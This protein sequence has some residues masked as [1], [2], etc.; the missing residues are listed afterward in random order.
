MYN[1]RKTE[2]E[3]RQYSLELACFQIS[4]NMEHMHWLS[5]FP[6]IS[7]FFFVNN[8]GPIVCK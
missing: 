4:L 7:V 2:I 5:Y 1:A 8:P 6:S 3:D